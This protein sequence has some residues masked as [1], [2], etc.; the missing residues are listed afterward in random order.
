MPLLSVGSNQEVATGDIK[1]SL[2]PRVA[3]FAIDSRERIRA[4]SKKDSERSIDRERPRNCCADA[5]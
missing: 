5:E 2:G 3:D 1:W 4:T